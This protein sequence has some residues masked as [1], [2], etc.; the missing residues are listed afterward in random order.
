MHSY[1]VC[2]LHRVP[3]AHLVR[4]AKRYVKSTIYL[5]LFH[6]HS[7]VNPASLRIEHGPI[8]LEFNALTIRPRILHPALVPSL[9][10]HYRHYAYFQSDNSS[11]YRRHA[12]IGSIKGFVFFPVI[13]LPKF[14]L[15][16]DSLV[17]SNSKK[18]G[19]GAERINQK[20][21]EGC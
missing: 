8:D 14:W 15:T 7:T 1:V 17:Q 9:L 4:Q 10:S 2:V 18:Y 13:S 5:C 19:G 3:Q 21:A 6:K 12:K 11:P 16:S 20:P